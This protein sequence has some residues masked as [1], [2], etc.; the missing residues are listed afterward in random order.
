MVSKPDTTWFQL[1]VLE[2]RN[3]QVFLIQT[4]G[5]YKG[6]PLRHSNTEIGFSDFQFTFIWLRKNDTQPLRFHAVEN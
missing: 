1:S 4:T 2:S 6:Y 3:L 5:Q